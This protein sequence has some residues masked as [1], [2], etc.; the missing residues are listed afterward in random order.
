MTAARIA[1]G[2]TGPAGSLLIGAEGRR[3]L[4]GRQCEEAFRKEKIAF[5]PADFCMAQPVLNRF[6]RGNRG[7]CT[8]ICAIKHSGIGTKM[9]VGGMEILGVCYCPP[10]AKKSGKRS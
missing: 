2:R 10:A 7:D 9:Y 6:I 1:V 3:H 5:T 8:T 4:N